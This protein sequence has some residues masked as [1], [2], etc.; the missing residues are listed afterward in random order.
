M[1]IISGKIFFEPKKGPTGRL[2]KPPERI[3]NKLYLMHGFFVKPEN[4]EVSVTLARG[5]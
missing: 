5:L 3:L 2:M 1:I 4:R